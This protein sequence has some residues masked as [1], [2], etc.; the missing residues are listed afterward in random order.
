MGLVSAG[1]ARF[2]GFAFA[3][4]D[5][6]FELD[7]KGRIGFAMGAVRELLGAGEAELIGRSWRELVA[8]A[9]HPVID[10]F[11]SGLSA[12]VRAGPV[13][14]RLRRLDG[15]DASPR[16]SLSAFRLG[17]LGGA[18]SC[19]LSLARTAGMKGV[20]ELLQNVGALIARPTGPLDL[21]LVELPGLAA[22]VGRPDH[23]TIVEAIDAVL[24]SEA[25]GDAAAQVNDERFALVRDAGRSREVLVQS[26]ERLSREHGDAFAVNAQS[27]S[28]PLD[29]DPDLLLKAV[30]YSLQRFLEAGADAARQTFEDVLR[31]T[32]IAAAD[33]ATLVREER[34]GLAFQPIVA[35]D[36]GELSHFEVLARF[37]DGSPQ[38]TILMAEALDLIE[39][40]DLAVSGKAAA[41]LRHQD[42]RGLK[43]AVNLSARSLV[44]PFFI[45]RLIGRL[46]DGRGLKGRLS[47]E[48]TETA[49]ITDIAAANLLV[50]QIRNRGFKV[51]LDDF[52]AGAATLAYLQGFNV[53]A[54]KI[55][56]QYVKALSAESRD[57]AVVRHLVKLCDELGIATIAEMIETEETAEVLRGLGVGYGQGWLF[58]R[59]GPTPVYAPPAQP[60]RGAA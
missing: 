20:E 38:K 5:L 16:V 59:P 49:Q 45:S 27:I 2:L 10:E 21:D 15:A 57:G 24:R 18:I 26:L 41:L 19:A 33:F 50:Q 58:G 9:D 47:F 55:D 17:E 1:T 29:E 28:L 46:G 35:L 7:A 52:G 48:L 11:L 51:S 13:G 3:S 36:T 44:K 4:A 60:L 54:L 53:D 25:V 32:L 34:F 23:G 22:R 30:R 42:N 43:L 8:E 31:N 6:L 14:F 12:G 39:D 37:G 56:G 40:F